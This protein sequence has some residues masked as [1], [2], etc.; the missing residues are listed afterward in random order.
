MIGGTM[1]QLTPE[2]A[3]RLS[4]AARKATWVIRRYQIARLSAFLRAARR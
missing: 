4:V 1:E 2:Q 3:K